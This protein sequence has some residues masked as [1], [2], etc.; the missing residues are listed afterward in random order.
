MQN[1]GKFS[2]FYFKKSFRIVAK[3]V[4]R[5]AQKFDIMSLILYY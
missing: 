4:K 1:I 3:E 5:V 2:M